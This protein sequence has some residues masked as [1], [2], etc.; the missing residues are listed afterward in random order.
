MNIPV[1][2]G[3][4]REGRESEKAARF[5]LSE[6]KK[7]GLDSEIIDV[8][9]FTTGV[10]DRTKTSAKAKKFIEKISKA[11]AL[12]IV[13]P[14]YNHGYPGEL[15]I[16]LDSAYEEYFGKP[17]G[18]CGVSSGGLGGARMTEQLRLVCIE[19]HMLPIREAVY[20]SGILQLFDSAGKIKDAS[21]SDRLKKFF[22]ELENYAKLLRKK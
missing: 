9:D 13:S 12:I 2:L 19:L 17:V 11:D 8:R 6:A 1:I 21:Y 3:T 15:K 16:L 4:A 22:Q 20:F 7:Y 18:I 10:T 14:E 5:V